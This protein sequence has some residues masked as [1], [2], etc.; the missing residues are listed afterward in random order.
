M[1]LTI[2]GSAAAEGWPALF[3]ECPACREARRRGGRN[4][5]RRT[6][7]RIDPDTLI[8]FGP[9]A[10]WQST[11]F[12]IDLSK[13]R[14]ILLTHSHEDHLNPVDLLWRRKGFSSVG[15]PLTLYGNAASLE[16]IALAF[17]EAPELYRSELKMLSPARKVPV[18][19]L[20]VTPL[21]AQHAGPQETALNFVI[22]HGEK[23]VLIANDTGWWPKNTWDRIQA[24]KLDIAIIDCTYGLANPKERAHHL[25]ALA[26]VAMKERLVALDVLKPRCTVVAN[27]FSH[28]GLG[29]H[30]E[31][32][33][34]F[35][36]HGI[37]VG[38][39]GMV[40]QTP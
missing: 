30:E 7:Y 18:G 24:F 27:H 17:P 5:R 37:E 31:L 1:R 25:G 38:Y 33:E 9:D 40:L 16:R 32:C 20:Q 14:H 39:D 34:W 8:D 26:V 19:D 4:I 13:V 10:F 6:A 2:L 28:N 23:A 21:E 3:C 15:A 35:A 22:E 29:L 11:A 12:G 36:P